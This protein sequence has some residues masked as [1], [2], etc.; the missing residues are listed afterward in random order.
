M[1][2][3][4]RLKTRLKSKRKTRFMMA[5]SGD[6]MERLD[7]RLEK[8]NVLYEQN[9]IRWMSRTEVIE[10]AVLDFLDGC[11]KSDAEMQAGVDAMY[12]GKK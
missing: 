6:V 7:A 8:L 5:L 11:D 2:A 4:E 12:G 9:Q 3:R 1:S 10:M